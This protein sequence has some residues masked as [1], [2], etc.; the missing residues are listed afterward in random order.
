MLRSRITGWLTSGVP[1]KMD[2]ALLVAACGF[3]FGVWQMHESSMA[4]HA[5]DAAALRSDSLAAVV[6]TTRHINGVL[7]TN[8][9]LVTRRA[10]QT[11]LHADS[12]DK[13][14]DITSRALVSMSARVAEIHTSAVAHVSDSNT[15]RFADF[16]VRREPF[17]ID[18][19]ASLPAPPAT[20]TLD[21][22]AKVDTA[23][24]GVRMACSKGV[25]VNS[26][27]VYV[28]TPKW[29]TVRVDSVKQ[30]AAICNAQMERHTSKW[31]K[32]LNIASFISGIFIGSRL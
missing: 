15:V 32:V 4:A 2:A 19:H 28:D 21:V 23:R 11:Q 31:T 3:G 20:G 13:K 7:S 6:D 5:R 18:A 10:V 8:L 26:A 27:S 22:D 1:T 17:T 30:D 14:L 25:D 12:V 29:L 24:I 16:H 9:N